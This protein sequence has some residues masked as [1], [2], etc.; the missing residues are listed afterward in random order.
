M[1]HIIEHCDIFVVLSV[2]PTK[3]GD[4]D[5]LLILQVNA[6]PE[7]TPAISKRTLKLF[8]KWKMSESDKLLMDDRQQVVDFQLYH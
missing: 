6:P 4:Y 8:V 5:S 1:K 2:L 3:T 7:G